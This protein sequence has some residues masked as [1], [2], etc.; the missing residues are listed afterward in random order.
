MVL[1]RADRPIGAWRTWWGGEPTLAE[2]LSDSIVKAV[3]AADGVD[4]EALAAQLR[5][6][7]HDMAAVRHASEERPPLFE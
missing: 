1:W 4:P 7:A 6:V 3:M 5:R 2:M